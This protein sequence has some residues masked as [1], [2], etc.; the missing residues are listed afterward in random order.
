MRLLLDTHTLLWFLANDARLSPMRRQPSRIR[1]MS[2]GSR[3]SAYS[4]SPSRCASASC[5]CRTAVRRDVSRRPA[6]RRHPSDAART[7]THRAA[8]NAPATSQRPVRP[9]HRSNRAGRGPDPRLRRPSLRRIRCDAT[10]VKIDFW[11]GE[12]GHPVLPI[13]ADWTVRNRLSG[14]KWLAPKSV[15]AGHG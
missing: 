5:R 4:R 9:P 10:L 6:D 1:R 2:A 8:H 14:H 7:G 3:R 11:C 12:G 13:A 15:R